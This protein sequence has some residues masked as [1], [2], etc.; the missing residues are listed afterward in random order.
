MSAQERGVETKLIERL[1]HNLLDTGVGG[2]FDFLIRVGDA[3]G[4]Q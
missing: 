1:Y 3:V 4:G 2:N